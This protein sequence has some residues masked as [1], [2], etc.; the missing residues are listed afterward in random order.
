MNALYA[1]M[2]VTLG[3]LLAALLAVVVLPAY[4][5]RIDRFARETMKRELPLTEQELKADRDRLRA[6]H[7][8]QLHKLE[9]SIE[10]MRVSAARQVIDVNRRDAKIHELDEQIEDQ[11]LVMEEHENARRVLEQAIIDRLPK[12]EQR[13]TE[14]RKLLAQRDAEIGLLSETAS[15]QTTA[16]EEATQINEQQRSEL[17]RLR[18]ALD[19]RAARNKE[20][21][22]DPR[23]DGEVA[24][25]SEVEA[26]RSK[27]R[28]QESLIKKLQSLEHKGKDRVRLA[29]REKEVAELKLEIS[30]L[31]SEYDVLKGAS[32]GDEA[33]AVVLTRQIDELQRNEKAQAR[34]IARLKAAA[35]VRGL[36]KDGATTTASSAESAGNTLGTK[37]EIEAIRN[38]LAEA[39]GVANRLE[40]ELKLAQE[41]LA[42]QAEEFR[43]ELHRL[44]VQVVNARA[45]NTP[46]EEPR[47]RPS[48][49]ERMAA[50]RPPRLA[51]VNT[52]AVDDEA[53]SDVPS[54][55]QVTSDDAT[56]AAPPSPSHAAQEE[57]Q[58]HAHVGASSNGLAAGNGHGEARVSPVEDKPRVAAAAQDA[59]QAAGRQAGETPRRVRLLDRI[60]Q[61]DKQQS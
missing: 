60:S 56:D 7:A 3:F 52:L 20:T 61:L 9:A 10:Q 28:E 1:G 21:L 4:R 40:S 50:P 11:K 49:V 36:S 5:R 18:A 47:R 48:L 55:R 12:V 19:T 31:Q 34:E 42:R 54:D 30:K 27:T 23:F 59:G 35:A 44:S 8:M 41:R 22:G 51:S 38:E 57:N 15:K 43:D 26:L 14:T 6:E 39:H 29:A 25:R 13:L 24:L 58:Q 17:E 53:D 46:P 32:D 2:L 16:L 37:A 33:I 45:S